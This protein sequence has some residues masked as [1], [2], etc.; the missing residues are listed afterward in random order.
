MEPISLI[1]AAL[2]AGA[3]AG[4]LDALKDDVAD[5]AKAAYAKLRGLAKKRVAGNPVAETALAQYEARPK[6]WAAPLADE[7]AKSGAANDSELVAAAK[8]LMELMDQAGAKA[9]KYNVTIKDSMGVQVGDH[10]FQV[11]TFNG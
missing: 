4:A 1:L 9:G 3:S 5:K 10:G 7:L 8:A 6:I 11:N 2:T